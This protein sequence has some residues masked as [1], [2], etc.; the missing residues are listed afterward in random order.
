[1]LL[2]KQVLKNGLLNFVKESENT[3]EL[4]SVSTD[5]NKGYWL[6]KGVLY[7]NS[8]YNIHAAKKVKIN[9]LQK[10]TVYYITTMNENTKKLCNVL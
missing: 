6:Y 4:Y 9:Q 3:T 7:D 5:I 10:N 8:V 2:R 1:M